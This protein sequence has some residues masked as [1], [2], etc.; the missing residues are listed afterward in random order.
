[1]TRIDGRVAVV[2]GAGSGIGRALGLELARR[3]CR[4]ALSD[5]VA[6]RV[7][8]TAEQCRRLGADVLETRVDVADADAVAAHAVEVVDRFGT[9]HLVFNNAGVA[10]T[11]HAH[12]QSLEDIRRVIDVNLW[13]VIHGSQA[14]LPHLIA[15][16]DGHLVNVSSLFGLIAV[17]S[18]SAYN[19]SKFGV[20]GYT[21]S[22]AA[23][24]HALRAPVRVSCV[25]P[26]GVDTRI[27]VDA[28]VGPDQDHEALV[29]EFSRVSRT[30]PLTAARTILRGVER[31]QFRILV[32]PDAHALGLLP[33]L[34]GG[35]AMRLIGLATRRRLASRPLPSAAAGGLAAFNGQRAPDGRTPPARS[36]AGRRS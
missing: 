8:A 2:T 13:G 4:L 7:R 22:L 5:V 14:F 27:V 16:R 1:M 29:E 33:R 21:E 36:R 34:L 9:V 24:L 6:E 3:G 35:R 17:P 18:Q 10:H 20:R 32:G 30:T 31:N 15:G 23:E 11:A 26:G 25:H 28:T 19:A 12:Q